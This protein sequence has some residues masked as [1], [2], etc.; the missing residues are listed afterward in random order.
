[1]QW[2][3][4]TVD[5][6]EGRSPETIL[7]AVLPKLSAGSIILSHNNGFG[8]ETY[9]PQ[10]IEYAQNEGYRFVTIPELLPDGE[11]TVDNNGLCKPAD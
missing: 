2:N 8:I 6:K 9:L 3:L 5:W 7:N 11:R 10:L 1:M 4:D